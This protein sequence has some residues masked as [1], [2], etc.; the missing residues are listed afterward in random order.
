MANIEELI[1]PPDVV[2]NIPTFGIPGRLFF[3][4]DEGKTYRDTGSA[5]ED[6]SPPPGGG[7][8]ADITYTP[9]VNT[10]WDGD[11]DPGDVDNALDQLA[12]RVDDLEGAGGGGSGLT[13]RASTVTTADVT[14]I[15]DSYYN[16]TVGGM[17]ADRNA[18]FP[19]PSAAGKVIEWFINDGDDAFEL[20]FK[21]D[22]G[23]TINGGSAATEWSREFIAGESGRAVSTSTTN[24]QIVV[25]GRI[26]CH[27]QMTLSANDTVNTADTLTLPTWDNAPINTGNICDTTNYRFNIRR[28]GKYRVSGDYRAAANIADQNYVF[29]FVYLNGTG[30]TKVTESDA[31]QSGSSTT[32]SSG[33]SPRSVTCAAGDYLDF[34]YQP[35]ASNRGINSNKSFF[36]VV[37]V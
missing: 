32:S 1:L 4:T 14:M 10:D 8:A 36:E 35:Q 22:T 26:P 18:I 28:A 37:E 9:A 30:G 23:I 21:G 7:D 20:I 11:T 5:W 19:A 13:Y 6:Y 27:G 15:E 33:L 16:F 25:D 24:W 31:R 29:L 12:E 17:T 2:A 3:A 34:W